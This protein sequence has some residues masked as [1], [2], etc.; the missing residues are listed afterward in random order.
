M[1][2]TTIDLYYFK[3]RLRKYRIVKDGY[4]G[5]QCDVWR[6]WFPFWIQMGFSNTFSSIEKAEEYIRI[7]NTIKYVEK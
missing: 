3:L 1:K 6:L 5:Y 4:L 2:T 7:K